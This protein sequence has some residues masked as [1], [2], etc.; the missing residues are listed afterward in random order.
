VQD[1]ILTWSLRVADLTDA[2]ATFVILVATLEAAIRSAIAF[3]HFR[4]ARQGVQ[5]I[6]WRF[7]R[8]LALALD[9][10][11][12]GDILR[13]GVAPSW[14]EIGQLAAIVAIRIV[15]TISLT[16]EERDIATDRVEAA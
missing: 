15:I 3:A 7:G 4:Q 10:L 1:F 13:T 6:R 11:I 8:W 12:A 16:R 14:V 5:L 9:F 2:C